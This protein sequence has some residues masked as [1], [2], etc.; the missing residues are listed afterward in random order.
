[1]TKDKQWL[2]LVGG[3][4]STSEITQG[5]GASLISDVAIP[6]SNTLLHQSTGLQEIFATW[7]PASGGSSRGTVIG[8]MH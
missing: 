1:M 5:S 6:G 4:I 7:Q 3:S 2:T 8:S